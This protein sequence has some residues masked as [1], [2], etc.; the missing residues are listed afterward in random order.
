MKIKI[1]LIIFFTLVISIIIGLLFKMQLVQESTNTPTPSIDKLA[2]TQ[3]PSISFQFTSPSN[4]KNVPLNQVITATISKLVK[5]ED[6][7]FYIGPKTPF[8]ITLSENTISVHLKKLLL[9]NTKYT[10]LFEYVPTKTFSN[11]YE[12]STLGGGKINVQNT[13]TSDALIERNAIQL[14]DTP[15]IYLTNQTPYQSTIFKIES[16]YE[17]KNNKDHYYFTITKKQGSEEEVK[18]AVHNWLISKGMNETQISKLDI[19]Y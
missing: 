8:E 14:R 11:T 10:I 17:V 16:G 2:V 7:Q 19:R 4:V 3:S 12:F 15:D 9:P 18:N 1:V 6:I 13:T 5:K